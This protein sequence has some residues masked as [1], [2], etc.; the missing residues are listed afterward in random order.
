MN[1]DIESNN[2][3]DKNIQYKDI[4]SYEINNDELQITLKNNDIIIPI[5]NINDIEYV[6]HMAS[7]KLI[8]DILTI[9]GL[10]VLLISPS[11]YMFMVGQNSYGLLSISLLTMYNLIILSLFTFYYTLKKNWGVQINSDNLD[12]FISGNDTHSDIVNVNN[13]I[14]NEYNVEYIK[15]VGSIPDIL[16]YIINKLIYSVK[17]SIKHRSTILKYTIFIIQFI[18][19]LISVVVSSIKDS[20]KEGFEKR[21]K[22]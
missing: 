14:H 22:K 16:K 1:N 7:N 2:V 6:N 8:I 11:V 12:L 21:F 4:V 15:M 10:L 18:Y 13:S 20:F 19:M 9:L 3:E 5:K 17:W